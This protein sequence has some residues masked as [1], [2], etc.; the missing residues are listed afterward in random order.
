M[1][2]TDRTFL[3]TSS[4]DIVTIIHVADKSI[5]CTHKW[6]DTLWLP[7][8]VYPPRKYT[9]TTPVQWYQEASQPKARHMSL[10]TA[11]VD[12]SSH[13]VK[14]T[15][16]KS[17]CPQDYRL[18]ELQDPLSP[19]LLHMHRVYTLYR[20]LMATA[21]DTSTLLVPLPSHTQHMSN[22]R[23]KLTIDALFLVHVALHFLKI[24]IHIQSSLIPIGFFIYKVSPAGRQQTYCKK[25]GESL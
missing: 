10:A 24:S 15:G 9:H 7:D 19:G 22:L 3:D 14:K 2:T 13:A 12:L 16:K 1:P 23:Y 18:V 8:H 21:P 5:F 6:L 4:M 25:L 17:A 11:W 20:W